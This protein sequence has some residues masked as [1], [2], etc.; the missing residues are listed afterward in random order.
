MATNS[1]LDRTTLA[2]STFR[3]SIHHPLSEDRPAPAAVPQDSSGLGLSYPYLPISLSWFHW[4]HETDWPNDT[5]FEGNVVY[6]SKRRNI[7]LVDDRG[8][9]MSNNLKTHIYQSALLNIAVIL[10]S[11]PPPQGHNRQYYYRDRLHPVTTYHHS[12]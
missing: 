4:S 3:V 9:D 7:F 5:A 2:W 1:H 12:T 6:V 11:W 8:L 10:L